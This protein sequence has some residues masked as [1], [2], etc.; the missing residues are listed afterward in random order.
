MIADRSIVTV[1]RQTWYFS[2]VSLKRLIFKYR[3]VVIFLPLTNLVEVDTDLKLPIPP[4]PPPLKD[5]EEKEVTPPPMS[6]NEVKPT[7]KRELS[8]KMKRLIYNESRTCGLICWVQEQNDIGCGI[9]QTYCKNHK[10]LMNLVHT[11]PESNPEKPPNPGKP[12][13]AN[14]D[15][16]ILLRLAP[17]WRL[18]PP[19]KKSSKGSSAVK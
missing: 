1:N 10:D 2:T 14:S 16:P 18:R 17:L 5:E 6:P 8:I 19:P 15:P 9:V 3:F 11:V 12:P 4:P 7:K 13:K